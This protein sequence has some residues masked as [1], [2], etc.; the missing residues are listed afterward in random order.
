MT[1]LNER[2]TD[3]DLQ[4]FSVEP[5]VRDPPSYDTKNNWLCISANLTTKFS[6]PLARNRARRARN[7]NTHAQEHEGRGTEEPPTTVSVT[8]NAKEK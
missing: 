7:T 1:R 5:R 6:S 4:W 8:S 2:A 3:L